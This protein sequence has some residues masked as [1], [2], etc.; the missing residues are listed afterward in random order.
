MSPQVLFEQQWLRLSEEEGA[1]VLLGKARG[2]PSS[3]PLQMH[4]GEVSRQ[5]RF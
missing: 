1:Q 5:E 3:C 2:T 4:V